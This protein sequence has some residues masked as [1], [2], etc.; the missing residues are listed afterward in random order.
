MQSRHRAHA[1]QPLDVAVA[2]A[3]TQRA[4]VLISLVAQALPA[5]NST[6][7]L[8]WQL[9]QRPCA[10][11]N[12]GSHRHSRRMSGEARTSVSK[13]AGNGTALGGWEQQLVEYNAGQE[14][15]AQVWTDMG[16]MAL[17]PKQELFVRLVSDRREPLGV[18]FEARGLPAI[19]RHRVWVSGLIIAAVYLVISAEM[20]NR[21]L[22]AMV[23]GFLSLALL[24][25][26][27][28]PPS[29]K[30]V[31]SWMNESTLGLLF[32]MMVLIHFLAETGVFQWVRAHARTPPS[33]L[34]RTHA[35]TRPSIHACAHPRA[36][37]PIHP[38]LRAPTRAPTHPRLRAPTRA[39]THPRMQT[40]AHPHSRTP[41]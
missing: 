3:E 38:R 34:A 40:R 22:V 20:L 33:T 39:P 29:L 27:K 24:T 1:G 14:Q 12:A 18:F 28:G 4:M 5:G 9:R 35:R 19:A 2:D 30:V 37:P 6:V 11:A 26:V 8:R 31:I 7:R 23:G 41:A 36:H 25:W 21:T 10:A 32:G 15:E 13:C 17:D 16:G